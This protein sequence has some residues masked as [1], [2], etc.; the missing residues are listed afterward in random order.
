MW[1]ERSAVTM[2]LSINN[3][4]YPKFI[5]SNH[6]YHL[7]IQIRWIWKQ[8]TNRRVVLG[9][10]IIISIK[11]MERKNVFNA[12]LNSVLRSISPWEPAPFPENKG[13]CAACPCAPDKGFPCLFWLW[14][15]SQGW[16]QWCQ[17]VTDWGLARD[18]SEP[19]TGQAEMFLVCHRIKA[20]QRSCLYMQKIVVVMCFPVLSSLM[21]AVSIYSLDSSSPWAWTPG[22]W[23]AGRSSSRYLALSRAAPWLRCCS[24]GGCA[25]HVLQEQPLPQQDEV[26][27]APRPAPDPP[28]GWIACVRTV[29]MAPLWSPLQHRQALRF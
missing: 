15:R 10:T 17:L 11:Y 18:D 8:S 22:W 6:S 3:G 12:F 2:L 9:A 20:E 23:S 14:P 26:L 29:L 27:S 16:Q 7:A 28:R 5:C 13:S 1:D 21:S 24:G 19:V 4:T 25:V